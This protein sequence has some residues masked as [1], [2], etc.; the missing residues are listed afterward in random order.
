MFLQKF[1]PLFLAA[2]MLSAACDDSETPAP[3]VQERQRNQEPLPP[4]RSNP[5]T[6]TEPSKPERLEPAPVGGAPNAEA[7][8]EG[9]DH[10]YLFASEPREI[11]ALAADRS[12]APA[13]HYEEAG[14]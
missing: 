12:P 7:P 4:A 5:A 11:K 2:A 3:T 10:K 14:T 1:T 13:V 6:P 8:K 9:Q